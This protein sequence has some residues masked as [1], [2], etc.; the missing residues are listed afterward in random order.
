MLTGCTDTSYVEYDPKWEV[1]DASAC[2]TLGVSGPLTNNIKQAQVKY[3]GGKAYLVF[4]TRGSYN[5]NLR[6]IKG[7]LKHSFNSFE[8]GELEIPGSLTAGLYIAQVS[9]NQRNYSHTII[10]AK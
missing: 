2:E 8:G 7:A 3:R 6:D 10:T 5:I 4:N 9:D 1:A